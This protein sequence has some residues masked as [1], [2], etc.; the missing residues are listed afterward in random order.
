MSVRSVL[1][2]AQT[3]A[4][5]EHGYLLVSGLIPDAVSR[6]AESAMW[7][8]LGA[9]PDDPSTWPTQ[10]TGAVNYDDPD[11]VACYTPEVLAAAGQ[12][13]EGDPVN[14]AFRAPTRAHCLNILPQPEPW[15]PHG[16]HIDHAIKEHGHRTFPFAFRVAT[17]TYLND[18][19]RHSAATVVWPAS[20]RKM[21]ALARSDPARYEYMWVLNQDL[22]LGDVGEPVEV[23]AARG[24]VLFYHYLCVHSGSRNAGSRPRFA[25]NMKW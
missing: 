6:R 17:M 9:N 20:H 10:Q 8:A 2:R 4:Y 16:P 12:L 24:D 5:V 15:Q 21:A 19:E 18:V 11:L 14:A 3:E 25:M 7:R 23:L 1:T 13:G 22:H